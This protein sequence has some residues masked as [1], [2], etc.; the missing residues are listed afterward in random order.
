MGAV[1]I[2]AIREQLVGGSQ[3]W[4]GMGFSCSRANECIRACFDL[5]GL[6]TSATY[7]DDITELGDTAE[8]LSTVRNELAARYR[9]SGGGEFK[10]MLG[11]MIKQN[12]ENRTMRLSQ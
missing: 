4:A 10:Y 6:V 1:P 7:T 2:H 11:I 8:G 9:L 3:S 5:D 12:Q